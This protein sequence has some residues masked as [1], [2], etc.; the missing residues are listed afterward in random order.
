MDFQ[1]SGFIV[2]NYGWV[3]NIEKAGA[4]GV[5]YHIEINKTDIYKYVERD[6]YIER[7]RS[8]S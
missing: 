3:Y 6:I 8:L 2:G 1:E 7:S 5:A 4:Y